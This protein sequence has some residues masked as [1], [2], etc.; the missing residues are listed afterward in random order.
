MVVVAEGRPDADAPWCFPGRRLAV[1]GR[2]CTGGWELL[3]GELRLAALES[4]AVGD[5]PVAPVTLALGADAV[6][7]RGGVAFPWIERLTTW[8]DWPLLLWELVAP[9]ARVHARLWLAP[10]ARAVVVDGTGPADGELVGDGVL[11]LALDA[12]TGDES[13]RLRALAAQV[14][15]SSILASRRQAALRAA[16]GSPAWRFGDPALEAALRW[17]RGVAEV[18]GVAAP[19]AAPLDSSA[20]RRRLERLRDLPLT[21]RLDLD[22]E[23][24]ALVANAIDAAARGALGLGADRGDGVLRLRPVARLPWPR[25]G[26][27]GVRVGGTVLDVGLTR[28]DGRLGVRLERRQGPPVRVE[29]TLADAAVAA[30]A[31][32]DVPLG[33]GTAH[34]EL[35]GRHEVDFDLAEW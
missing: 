28:R 23:R 30:T 4:V 19:A 9:G 27:A 18:S 25:I 33:G 35:L 29:A 21:A 20:V 14:G 13:A 3:A 2:A 11:R 24:L 22:G 8:G 31:V 17:A 16:D 34:F 6:E 7:R 15:W 12:G 1:R 10:G 32:D 5:A 26:A